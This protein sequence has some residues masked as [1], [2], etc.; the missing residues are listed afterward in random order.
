MLWIELVCV[1]ILA[2]YLAVRLRRD[3]AP[4]ALLGRLALL[5]V[6]SWIG[7]NSVIHAYAFYQYA[8]G[9]HLFVDRVPLLIVL[10]WPVVIHSAW[11]LARALS[12]GPTAR[13][14]LG[15]GLLVLA[16]ASLIEPISVTAGLWSWNAPGLLGVPP[17]GVLGWAYFT[18]A[19]LAVF[20]AAERRGRPALLLLALLVGPLAVHAAVVVSW[21]GALRWVS[22]PLPP[23]PAVGVAAAVSALTCLL[24]AT[25]EAPRR[26]LR[27]DLLVRIPPVIF[28][29]VLLALHAHR[30]PAL[31]A[32]T[33]CFAPP[34]VILTIRALPTGRQ[35]V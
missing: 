21:W 11:D 30:A 20:A 2:L 18:V 22:A 7:E 14:V 24:A 28:F 5:S 35:A 12:G 26:V 10:I 4:A 31:V 32:Y 19:C 17:V 8:P 1:A 15:G 23:W 33:L 16:D 3:P 27:T 9:F 29:L 6:A 13:A 25:R 34:W